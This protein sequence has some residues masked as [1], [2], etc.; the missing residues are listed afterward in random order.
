MNVAKYTLKN[1]RFCRHASFTCM[2][3]DDMH[4]LFPCNYQLTQTYGI[5]HNFWT[6]T[7]MSKIQFFDIVEFLQLFCILYVF[8]VVCLFI[9]LFVYLFV[10]LFVFVF[11]FYFLFLFLFFAENMLSSDMFI[12]GF[13]YHDGWFMVFV[14]S[15]RCSNSQL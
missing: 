3:G 4:Y 15:E 11:V 10:C 9:Y 1:D 8:V 6:S 13:C 14:N 5:K 2:H 12:L 7:K